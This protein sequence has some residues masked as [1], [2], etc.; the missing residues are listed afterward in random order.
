MEVSCDDPGSSELET[1]RVSRSYTSI[2]AQCGVGG[3]VANE[4]SIADPISVVIVETQS[5][6]D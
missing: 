2:F 4:G 1:G 3:N 5:R 6:K